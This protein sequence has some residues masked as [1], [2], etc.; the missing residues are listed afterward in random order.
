MSNYIEKFSN[1]NGRFVMTGLNQSEELQSE[2]EI[3]RKTRENKNEK[4]DKNINR[5]N[6]SITK[7]YD[8]KIRRLNLP[9]QEEEK[10]YGLDEIERPYKVLTKSS[11]VIGK[12]KKTKDLYDKAI[13]N[14]ELID[15]RKER[16]KRRKNVISSY[17]KIIAI[18]VASLFFALI[19]GGIYYILS[20]PKK[21]IRY[22][23][24]FR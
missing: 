24:L 3:K 15:N 10:D 4:K 7:E 1:S 17:K 21:K 20:K 13:D 19:A 2:E 6:E 11:K 23:K 18:I 16:I 22:F 14:E 12:L 8:I 9:K 5:K